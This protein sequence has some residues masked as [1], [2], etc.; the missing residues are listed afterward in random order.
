M[1]EQSIYIVLSS[2]L[3]Y[4]ALQ[5]YQGGLSSTTTSVSINLDDSTVATE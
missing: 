3:L 4:A 5:S 2:V 1:N